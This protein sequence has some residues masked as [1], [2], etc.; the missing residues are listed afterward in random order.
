MMEVFS[1]NASSATITC[2]TFLKPNGRHLCAV[3]SGLSKKKMSL[4]AAMVFARAAS[5]FDVTS[6]TNVRA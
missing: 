5:F 2:G 6:S 3:S 4:P 1:A